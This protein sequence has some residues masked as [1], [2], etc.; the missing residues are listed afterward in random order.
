MNL[1]LACTRKSSDPR[2]LPT[3]PQFKQLSASNS[4]SAIWRLF[5]TS[6]TVIL[7]LLNTFVDILFK[8]ATTIFL[9]DSNTPIKGAAGVE[10]TPKRI[11]HL[12]L[13]LAHIKL[14]KTAVNSVIFT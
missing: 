7:M 14:V 4:T 5:S 11:V 3:F 9:K 12:T 8:T 1:L 6:W 2:D 10:L 13:S